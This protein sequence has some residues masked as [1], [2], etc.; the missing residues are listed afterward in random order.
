MQ[1]LNFI[2]SSCAL[3]FL[4]F[5]LHL[6]YAKQGTRMLN[7][8]LS[9]LFFVRSG[10]ISVYILIASDKLTIFPVFQNILTPFYYAAPA[11]FYLYLTGF[12]N[13]RSRFRKLDWLHLIPV[14]MA[15]IHVLPWHFA[16]TIHWNE[17]AKQILENKQLFI[18][19]ETGLLPAYFYYVGR[20]LLM[21][22]YLF[23]SWYAILTSRFFWEKEWDISKVWIFILLTVSTC[24]NVI[25]I[26]PLIFLFSNAWF[27][28][29]YCLILSSAILFILHQPRLLYGY[30]LLALDWKVNIFH[31][32]EDPA[33]PTANSFPKNNLLPGQ[34][35]AIY[36]ESMEGFMK[37]EKPFLNPGFQLAHLAQTLNIPAHHCS[38]VINNVIGKNFRDW[39][40]AYRIH[41]FIIAYPPLV[42]KMT[43]EAIA[44]HSGFKSVATFYNAFKKETGLMPTAYFSKKEKELI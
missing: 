1:I 35:L 27:I 24:T 39:I 23:A 37:N 25:S 17:I 2:I 28:A 16:P 43:V 40:N 7:R 19:Q 18:T 34:L 3:L 33:T 14:V 10:Q 8:L 15:I 6:F 20:P 36:A 31:P 13:G 38:Y 11:C 12:I 4:L 5:S 29:L 30:L 32:K 44:F 22:G 21:L 9:L 42:D 41:Y 26:L